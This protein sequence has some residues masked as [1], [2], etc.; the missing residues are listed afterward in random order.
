M[1]VE[2]MFM[3][4]NTK[5]V[6]KTIIVRDF[7]DLDDTVNETLESHD[8]SKRPVVI[9]K[10]EGRTPVDVAPGIE[11]VTPKTYYIYNF[12]DG[13]GNKVKIW[14]TNHVDSQMYW[15]QPGQSFQISFSSTFIE[16]SIGMRMPLLGVVGWR[17]TN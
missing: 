5:K 10:Y 4:S 9:L 13:Y 1:A 3:T 2:S 7:S 17:V 8:W 11:F 16:Q 14:G 12:I 6:Q 15:Q